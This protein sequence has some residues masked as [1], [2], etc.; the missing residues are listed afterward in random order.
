LPKRDRRVRHESRRLCH[1]RRT[2][3]FLIPPSL[4]LALVIVTIGL[5]NTAAILVPVA[6]AI[7]I[8]MYRFPVGLAIWLMAQISVWR[9]VNRS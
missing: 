7:R 8:G 1:P 5:V 2:W 3:I 9:Q 6:V 4:R